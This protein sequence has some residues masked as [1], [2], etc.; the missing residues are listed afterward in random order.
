VALVCLGNICRSP[1]ADVVLTQRVDDVGLAGRVTVSSC[2]TGD[3]H[4]GQPMD[5][6]AA[7]TLLAHDY[8][9]SQHR[10]RLFD[11]SWLE[12]HD[13]VLAMDA[14]NLRNVRGVV[15]SSGGETDPD[16]VRLFGDFDPVD[17]GGEVPDPYY[18]GEEGFEEVLAMVER[19]C[20]VLVAALERL[21]G[22]GNTSPA[23][24]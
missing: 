19:T 6:R 15:T 2:G 21:P 7:A 5:Q 22:L 16:R 10:A 12:R 17:P 14:G 23:D 13:L 9:P 8:D 1:M 4:L 11:A 24:S 20:A 18:G 3:W